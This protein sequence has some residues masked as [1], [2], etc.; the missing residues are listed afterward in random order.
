MSAAGE[1]ETRSRVRERGVAQDRRSRP[2][3]RVVA[4]ALAFRYTMQCKEATGVARL[5]GARRS[6]VNAELLVQGGRQ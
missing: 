1:A 5:P 3:A 2:R 4:D 6:D